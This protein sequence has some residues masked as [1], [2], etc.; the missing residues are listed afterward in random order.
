[1]K[2]Q[3]IH[4]PTF[5]NMDLIKDA[6]QLIDLVDNLNWNHNAIHSLLGNQV[7][8]PNLYMSHIISEGNNT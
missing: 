2:T 8:L 5:V 6:F 4:K 3:F 7:N 1:M